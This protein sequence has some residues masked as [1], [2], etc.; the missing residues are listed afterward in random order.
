MRESH[1][2]G[3]PFL[4]PVTADRLWLYPTSA[5]CR[6]PGAR[7]RAPAAATLARTCAG[8]THVACPGFREAT[9]ARAAP[10]E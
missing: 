10:R 2:E 5:F 3:C 7:V 1:D 8:S 9:V 4:V 6:R